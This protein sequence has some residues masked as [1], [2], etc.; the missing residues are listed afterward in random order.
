[1]IERQR[2]RCGAQ[3][4]T[5]IE[6]LVAMVIFSIASLGLAGLLTGTMRANMAAHHR[7]FA[8]AFAQDKVEEIRAGGAGACTGGTASQGSIT[9]SLACGTSGGPNGST[10]VTV[11]VTW[12]NP[13]SQSV[14]LQFRM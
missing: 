5:L 4:F 9:F 3:G 14:Q 6:V 12:A 11:T 7:S 8:T 10:N 13:S 1:M 2:F